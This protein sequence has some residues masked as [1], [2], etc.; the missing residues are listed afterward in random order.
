L[1]R[2]AWIAPPRTDTVVD[3]IAAAAGCIKNF[4]SPV[5]ESMEPYSDVI[6]ILWAAAMDCWGVCA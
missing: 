1:L 2:R 4:T 3:I 6:R 5:D